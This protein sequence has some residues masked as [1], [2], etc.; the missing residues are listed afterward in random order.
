QYLKFDILNEVQQVL[1][2][3]RNS[4][5]SG[6]TAT[7]TLQG[8]KLKRYVDTRLYI[9]A[10]SVLRESDVNWNLLK[11]TSIL[12]GYHAYTKLLNDRHAFDYS[13]ILQCIVQA[14]QQDTGLRLRLATRVKVVIV[15]EYQDVN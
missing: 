1:F 3:D 7:T 6:L 15:D 4:A 14:L 9:E 8:V 2:V 5:K 12:D 13:A 10:M 11:G